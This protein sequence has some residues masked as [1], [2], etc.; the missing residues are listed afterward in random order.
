[1]SPAPTSAQALAKLQH[2]E[3]EMWGPVI[4][5]SGFKAEE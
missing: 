5:A 3:R 1:M 4:K 2:D